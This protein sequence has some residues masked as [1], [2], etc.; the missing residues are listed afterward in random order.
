MKKIFTILF[1]LIALF[2]LDNASAKWQRLS[3]SLAT[4]NGQ[5]ALPKRYLVFSTDEAALKSQLFS[6][7]NIPSNGQVI[8]LP[9]PDGSLRNFRVW[10]SSLM[11]AA[12][13]AKYPQLRTFTAEA[14]DNPAITAKLDYTEYGF[15][16]MI[17]NGTNVSFIDPADNTH[18]G[19]YMVHYKKDEV[20][21][22][23]NRSKCLVPGLASVNN[24]GNQPSGTARKTSARTTNGY[25]LRTYRL[26]LA[27]S[28]QYADSATGLDNP[29][30][31]QVFSKMITS[32]NR[33]NGVYERELA[34]TMIFVANEDTL[35][36]PVVTGSVN[37]TDPYDAIN[38]DAG[39][40]LNANQTVCDSRIG[41]ANYDVGHVFTSGAGGLSEVGVA[42]DQGLKAMSVTG[43]PDPVGDGFDIDYV[44]HEMG[45][46]YGAD[47]PFNDAMYGSC[48]GSTIYPPCAYE[49][50]SG[51]TIMAYAGI[52][53]PDDLQPHSDAYF[54]SVSLNEI[55]TYITAAGDVCPVKTPTNNKLVDLPSFTA[56]YTIPYLTPFELTAPACTDS[57]SDSV[58]TYCWEQ[59]NLGDVGEDLVNTHAGGPIFRS[60]YPTTSPTRIFPE[61]SMVLAGK[62]SNAGIEDSEGEKAPDVARYLTFKL[63]MR[64]IY[65]GTGC[66]LI[67]D[68]SIHLDVIQTDTSFY[69]T[70]QDEPNLIYM[71]GSTQQ[72]TWHVAGT[73]A[74]PV[75]TTNVDIYMSVDG[76]N[77]WPYHIGNFI[78]NGSA[79]LTLPNPDTTATMARLKVKG[80]GNV[81]F[82]VNRND[83]TVTPGSPADTTVLLYPVPAQNTMR[84]S[85]GNKGLLQV[86][87]CNSVGQQIWTGTVDGETDIDVSTWARGLYIMRLAGSNNHSVKKFVVD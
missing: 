16:A 33:V 25:E 51:S 43:Q 84:L 28:H 59:K 42:C 40:C 83:F 68:D 78:N 71:G 61:N 77:T 60:Y 38:A 79:L 62:L 45:H 74:A 47:H 85:T 73:N 44:S 57:V 34:I 67:P 54:N 4:Q 80:T 14:V 49:P 2:N 21:E 81:F 58:V 3:I 35:I 29:S 39:S 12:L 55:E 37:G 87:V 13:A 19:N 52:C 72:V 63:T 66:F 31:A 20:R 18:S 65:E 9:M 82:N 36:W 32:M 46:E 41:N 64:D 53:P 26:A 5:S 8:E 27:C 70:S 11:P 50:G 7:S 17:F 23:S 10:S 56:S 30:I 86:S 76:G 22:F 48:S 75:N 69:V 1:F 6:L 15:H 24:T